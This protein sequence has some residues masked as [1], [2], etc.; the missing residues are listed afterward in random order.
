MSAPEVLEPSAEPDEAAPPLPR[1]QIN[2]IF[3]TI[4]L[5]MLLS[6]LDQT[7]VSTALPTI[8][9]D[10]GGAGHMSW[11]VTSYLLAA[12]I[13][14]VLAGKF[15]DL[16]GRKRI[17]QLSIVVF[18]VGSFFCGLAHNMT[19][20]IAARGVQGIG[21]GGIIVTATALIGDVI[22][23][24]ERGRY[25]GALGAVFGITTVIG[26]LLG[27]LFTD[28]LSWRWAFYVNVPLA[29]VV[30]A[31][32]ARTIPG[33]GGVGR[34]R[35]D[36]LGVLFVAL[37]A[38]GLTLATAWGGT[39]YPWAS[40]AIIGLFAGS[41]L[42]MAVFV[43]V[44]LRAAE[45]IL[46]MRLFRGRVFATASALSFIVGFAMFGALTF[47]PS[48][49]QYVGGASATM[50]G[51]RMLP[52]VVGLL[53]TAVLAGQVVGTTGRYKPFPVAGTAIT[54]LAL[55]LLSRMNQDTS[56]AV[57]SFY[58]LLLG[59][60]IGLSM[61]ILTIIV[62]STV[63]Y[64][65]LGAATSGVTFFRTLGGSFG[66]SI[67]GAVYTNRLAG[68]LPPALAEA[69]VPPAVAADPAAVHSLP[70]AARAP[71]V[72]A[73]TDAVHTIFLW[74]VPVA[75]L[76]LVVAVLLPQV[77]LRGTAR[78]AVRSP[79]EGFAMPVSQTSDAELETLI[80]YIARRNRDA[81]GDIVARSGAGVDMPTAWALLGVH[82]RA[83]L[84][85][86][87]TRQE[88]IERRLRIPRGVLTSFYDGV[89]AAGYLSRDA[90]HLCL[91]DSGR[92][93]VAALGDAWTTW[94]LDQLAESD[95][96][97]AVLDP[98]VR[99][100]IGRIARRLMAEQQQELA[101]A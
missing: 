39:Q 86:L 28:H 68:V 94:L 53:V 81:V 73:Y 44:E 64:R 91:T 40:A 25:Q 58:M 51:I 62:Q 75:L 8:V 85:N 88:D 101:P 16:F 98:R 83:R 77:T 66:A 100:A 37:G 87:P 24:R 61:Q 5:G 15:G 52:M 30:V 90:G 36:Y 43:L 59:A 1:T 9:S 14:T 63:E 4:L 7:I 79:G 13:S 49:L 78:E 84:L 97:R 20:L 76:G 74:A 10:L 3:G 35:I 29:V 93:A 72:G 65:D 67:M 71:V 47:L 48:Y 11:I 31:L 17:F 46:P 2:L 34:P 32:A 33:R 99:A 82:L 41:V 95:S 12:T 96:E 57:Q 23:L 18:V 56:V 45:P 54:A 26:P 42:A 38:S 27:G 69:K 80:S 6:A 50:S 89:A 55:Y 19:M 70:A 92:A 22:P 60:G 21:G